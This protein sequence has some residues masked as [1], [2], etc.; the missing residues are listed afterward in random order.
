MDF[1]ELAAKENTSIHLSK[2]EIEVLL[3]LKKGYFY[4]E[5][6]SELHISEQTVK[7]HLSNIYN[8]LDVRNKTEALNKLFG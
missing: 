4:K 2:R 8:K 5:V 6:G 7:K 3:S 1:P